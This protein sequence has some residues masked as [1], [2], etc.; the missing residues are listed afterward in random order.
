MEIISGVFEGKTTGSPICLLI[1]NKEFRSKDYEAIKDLLRPGHAMYTY[2]VRY[3]IYDYRGGGRAS[4]RETIGRVAAGALAKNFLKKHGIKITAYTKQV[5]DVQAKTIDL[6]EI[7]KNL[8][9]SHTFPA[10]T[11]DRLRSLQRHDADTAILN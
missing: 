4:G 3:G 1:R 9:R 7:E 8:I 11:T 5:A 10:H 6:S 2:L